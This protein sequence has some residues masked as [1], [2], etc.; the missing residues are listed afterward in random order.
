MEQ[1]KRI[2]SVRM[3]TA[4]LTKIKGIAARLQVRD[5]DVMRF[6]VRMGLTRLAPLYDPGVT[7]SELL[8][9]FIE[10]GA[11]LASYFDMDARQLES[12][13]NGG[14]DPSERRVDKAD[15][16]LLSRSSAGEH[17]VNIKL[18]E[19]ADRPLR[20]L[21]PSSLLRQ[22]LYEKYVYDTDRV[23]KEVAAEIGDG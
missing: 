20:P 11:E 23:E 4:D 1:R 15:I 8:P 7:G 5:S 22:Y 2:V 9:A 14:M 3:S 12:I 6:A 19:L 21:G 10:C 16:E 13:I 18:Q 17:A